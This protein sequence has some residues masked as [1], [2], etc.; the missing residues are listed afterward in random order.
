MDAWIYSI[1]VAQSPLQAIAFS[2]KQDELMIS[3]DPAQSERNPKF[4]WHVKANRKPYPAQIVDRNR[5]GLNQFEDSNQTSIPLI[6]DLNDTSWG[7]SNRYQPCDERNEQRFVRF[8]ERNVYE[9]TAPS[10]CLLRPHL[11]GNLGLNIDPNRLQSAN[12]VADL[13]RLDPKGFLDF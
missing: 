2:L 11:A 5:T 3:L 8:V 6:G 4:K 13:R 10:E 9:N 12:N 1:Y 7:S